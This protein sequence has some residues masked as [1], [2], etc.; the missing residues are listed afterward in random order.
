MQIQVIRFPGHGLKTLNVS[1]ETTIR[2]LCNKY[3][4]KCVI[5]KTQVPEEELDTLVQE[6]VEYYFLGPV[7]LVGPGVS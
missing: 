7:K 5:N 2:D 6:K 4:C 1:T 3:N